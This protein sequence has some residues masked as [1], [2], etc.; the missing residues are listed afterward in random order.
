MLLTDRGQD[1]NVRCHER[2]VP[3]HVAGCVDPDL[4]QGASDVRAQLLQGLGDAELTVLRPL[5][6]GESE[7]RRQDGGGEF[8]G[9]GLA[10][11]ATNGDHRP[12]EAPM[13]GPRDGAV[14]P[15]G[16]VHLHQAPAEG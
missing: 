16:V 11:A 12:G 5:G 10:R 7:T 2:S 3:R 8:L 13:K 15:M 1:A 14:G 9:G 6:L 4:D